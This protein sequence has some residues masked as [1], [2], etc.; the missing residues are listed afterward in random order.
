MAPPVAA[1]LGRCLL[2]AASE[3]AP[4][5]T[6]VVE[7]GVI[8]IRFHNILPN[9]LNLRPGC[10]PATEYILSKGGLEFDRWK[11]AMC[12]SLLCGG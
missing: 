3:D 2:M 7:V 12:F 9:P 6:P 1:A 11:W 4:V 5:A 10:I 8:D